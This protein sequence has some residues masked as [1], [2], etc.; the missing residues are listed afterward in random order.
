MYSK[1]ICKKI[2]FVYLLSSVATLQ[3]FFYIRL[4]R[5]PVPM[6]STVSTQY[7][8]RNKPIYDMIYC[9]STDCKF[10]ITY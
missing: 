7:A 1:Y 5:N 6:Y 8:L 10:N 3:L 2:K 9:F 4:C